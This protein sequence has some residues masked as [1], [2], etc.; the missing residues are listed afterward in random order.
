MEA[1]HLKAVTF[2]HNTAKQPALTDI[3]LTVRT[4][5]LVMLM[6]P[7]GSGK[8]TLLKLLKPEI[9]PF[10]EL[11]GEISLL[12]EKRGGTAPRVGYV[13]Q[14]PE[15]S[16]VSDRVRGEIMF[17]PE[18]AGLPPEEV[19]RLTA[20]TVSRF[21]L[22]KLLERP[23]ASLSGGE[24]QLVSLCAVMVMQP[25]LLLLDEPFSR[26]D[27]VTAENFAD[28]ILRVNRE[29]GTTVII[30]EH[31]GELMLAQAERLIYLEN[32]RLT[33][34]L[35]PRQAAKNAQ[36]IHIMP[37]AARAF[38]EQEPVPMTVKEGR[39]LLEKLP[40]KTELPLDETQGYS[41]PVL[42]AEGLRFS[43]RRDSEDI[44]AG[45]DLVLHKG[46]FLALT[47]ANGSGKT[48][49]LKTLAGQ[50]RPYAGKVRIGGRP[51]KKAPLTAA[52]LPQ[53]A[54]D[55][56][57]QP[58]VAEDYRYALKALGRP[59]EEASAMLGYLGCEKLADMHPYDLSGGELQLCA[60]GRVLLCQPDI[61]LLDEPSKGLDPLSARRLG[62]VLKKLCAE[63]KA[64][65]TVT[66]SL[67]FAAENAC[68]CGIFCGGRIESLLPAPK[69]FSKAGFYSTA[70]G[71]IARGMVKNAY[72][73]EKLRQAPEGSHA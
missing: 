19:R 23:L 40:H 3:S 63:G 56:F 25:D 49:L 72:T 35:P 6:G 65:L 17:A 73:V 58:T 42:E 69:F 26:L 21:G 46:E 28:L 12:G 53:E 24:K 37:A 8:T 31:S 71:R 38:A 7:S 67:E 52:M 59:E 30:A 70:S 10:G 45:A 54:A 16:F 2:R 64:V 29:F 15:E 41:E 20:E 27:P 4:G 18:N 50:L 33:A 13:P 66:H 9:A 60:L 39:A 68:T 14:H 43:F 44:L 5:E 57:L 55:L 22:G 62:T 48:T 34:D 61:L 36:L 47:G 51:L 1:V 11:S 32:G